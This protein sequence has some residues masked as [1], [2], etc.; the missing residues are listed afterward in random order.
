MDG[1]VCYKDRVVIPDDLQRM[2]L[3]TLYSVSSSMV[4]RA[5][6]TIFWP[7]IRVM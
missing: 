1:V 7:A 6:K 5:E 2:V 4:N 3:G